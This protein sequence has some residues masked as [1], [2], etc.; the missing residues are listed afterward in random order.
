MTTTY[1][2]PSIHGWPFGNSYDKSIVFE[3]VELKDIGFCGGMCWLALRRFFNAQLIPRD[4]A[5]PVEGDPLFDDLWDLQLASLSPSK[6]VKMY[7]WQSSPDLSHRFR[8][9][10]LGHRTKK[11]W[12]GV[13]SKL[14]AGKPVT[15]TLINGS[16][17]FNPGHMDQHHRVVAYAYKEESISGGSGVPA[18]AH[19]KVTI[20]IYDPNK[21][22][23]DNVYLTFYLGAKRSRIRLRHSEEGN[24]YH[25]FFRDDKDRRFNFSGATEV[26]ITNCTKKAII[27]VNRTEY[28]LSFFWKCRF[29]PYFNIIINNV[30]WNYNKAAGE[31]K[32][33][34]APTDKDNKQCNSRIGNLTLTLKLPRAISSIVVELVNDN[35]YQANVVVDASPAI[36][37]YPYIHERHVSK[38]PCVYDKKINDPD[39][40]SM[41]DDPTTAQMHVLDTSIFHWVKADSHTGVHTQ[42]L[43]VRNPLTS[44][45]IS[46]LLRHQLGNVVIPI[47]ANFDT[48]NMELPLNNKVGTVRITRDGV[49][50]DNIN[51]PNFADVAQKIFDGFKDN[52]NDYSKDT[53][54]KFEYQCT[55]SFGAIARGETYFY[56]KSII[57]RRSTHMIEVIDLRNLVKLE[58]IA[59][60]LIE[61]GLIEKEID[62]LPHA[63]PDPLPDPE[64]Y[65]ER[66]RGNPR[67]E[68]RIEE[69]FKIEWRNKRTWNKILNLQIEY[70]DQE[71]EF[72]PEATTRYRKGQTIKEN[73]RQINSQKKELESILLNVLVEK[74]INK[75]YKN[76]QFVDELRGLIL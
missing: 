35:Q 67:I 30:N 41:V 70:M 16:N 20:M 21:V 18:N 24:L 2:R 61:W 58:A 68:A 73:K 39:I 45:Y 17:N 26:S 13:R 75:L 3:D 36:E 50:L 27:S 47:Y 15:L 49:P 76:E 34:Y 8:K 64:A 1:F 40:F 9:H 5:A 37:C 69:S 62:L 28:D 46:T 44:Q 72:I 12:P 23:N 63:G 31:V 59:H 53:V 7:N 51:Y 52:P 6:L 54:V 14:N 56:G 48:R 43:V 55:D 33:N 10:S 25:G 32:C 71:Q 42:R 29:I 11:A 66:L 57:M 4:L 22:N 19:T 65:L 38:E 74:T 60:K